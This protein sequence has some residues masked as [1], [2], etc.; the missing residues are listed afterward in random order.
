VPKNEIE[1]LA[2]FSIAA[3]SGDENALFWRTELERRLD[4]QT[5]LLAQQRSKEIFD[6]IEA[7]KVN[8]MTAK[9]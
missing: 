9:P 1:A 8:K 5:S 4:R 7:A 6:R 2:W 3:A